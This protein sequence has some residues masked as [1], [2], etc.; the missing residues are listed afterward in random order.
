[1][2][3]FPTKVFSVLFLVSVMFVSGCV[4]EQPIGGQTDDHDCRLMEGYTWCDSKRKCLR[5]WEEDCPSDILTPEGCEAEGGRVQNIV[6]GVECNGNETAI[7]GVSGFISPNLCCKPKELTCA[8]EGG[9]LSST[10]CCS[11]VDDFPDTCNLDDCGC[12]PNS[13]RVVKTCYCGEGRCFDGN[14]C[15]AEVTDFDTCVSAGYPVMEIMP[16]QCSTPDG[17]VFT[18]TE[19][20]CTSPEGGS[21]NLEDA[22]QIAL[23]SDCI[24]EGP[25]TEY[26]MCNSFTGTWWFDMDADKPGCNPACVVNIATGDAEIN[27]RC[28]GIIED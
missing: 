14:G 5:A 12:A 22:R 21:M 16:R 11:T 4:Q 27:W 25:L 1:M 20:L 15:I 17:K 8:E 26:Y 18:D 2:D 10:L 13:S 3:Y 23:V 28:T 9:T 6:G 19:N 7:G 24:D